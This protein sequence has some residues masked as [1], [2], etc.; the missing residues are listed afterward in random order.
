MYDVVI[1]GAGVIGGGWGVYRVRHHR[2]P[3]AGRAGRIGQVRFY[4]DGAPRARR[5]AVHGVQAGVQSLPL[6]GKVAFAK[7][8]TDEV[9]AEQRE[10]S[11]PDF[12]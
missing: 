7:Q 8:M 4:R 5:M 12:D 9:G 1:I 6:E 2:H 11:N 10:E 3:G